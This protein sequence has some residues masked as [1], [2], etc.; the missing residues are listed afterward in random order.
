MEP[1]HMRIENVEREPMP[2]GMKL[3]VLVFGGIAVV[4]VAGALFAGCADPQQAQAVVQEFTARTVE[5][6]EAEGLSPSDATDADR[7]RIGA[8]IATE[9]LAEIGGTLPEPEPPKD[10]LEFGLGALATFLS[11][12][13]SVFGA[14]AVGAILRGKQTRGTELLGV[15]ASPET[16]WPDTAKAISAAL[17]DTRSP[18]DP[19]SSAEAN[20]TVGLKSNGD[21]S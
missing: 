19:R 8:K 5:A 17:F 10:W 18:L 9:M 1:K 2:L 11:V 3:W 16:S 20:P 13:G 6:M 21:A 14:Q 4:L 7:K 15:I 12:K